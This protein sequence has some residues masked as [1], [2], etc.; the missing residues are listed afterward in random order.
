[1]A[2]MSLAYSTWFLDKNTYKSNSQERK[3]PLF[4]E[5]DVM[6][7]LGPAGII[8]KT[9]QNYHAIG[10]PGGGEALS[11]LSTHV[12][13]PRA[14]REQMGYTVSSTAQKSCLLEMRDRETKNTPRFRWFLRETDWLDL[15][16]HPTAFKDVP[17][18]TDD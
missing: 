13:Y 5:K 15:K 10:E 1:M 17:N 8:I 9:P 18:T 2:S 6:F 11:K 4:W 14:V 16:F 12:C 3:F 7:H